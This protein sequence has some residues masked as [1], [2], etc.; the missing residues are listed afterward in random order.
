MKGKVA[1]VT[2]GGQGIGK[3]IAKA[4]VEAGAKVAIAEIDEDAGR[5]TERQLARS[6]TVR[7]VPCDVA[8]EESVQDCVVTAVRR[9]GRLDFVINNA[10]IGMWKPVEQ[11]SV[12][13]WRRV[14]DT[15]LT[16]TFLFARHAARY[17]RKTRGAI[18]NIASTRA[19][20]SEPNTEA[21]SASKG[22]VVSLTHSLA[23]SLGPAIRVNCISPGWIDVNG[24]KKSPRK[25]DVR[26]VDRAFHPV[27]RVGEPED[28][29]ATAL[30]LCSPQA[31]FI[32]G[33]NVTI[34]GGVTR[35]MIYPQ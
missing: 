27:G 1:I 8:S 33:I 25:S 7:F 30:F 6:G 28:I 23:I 4:F 14:L 10:G 31:G 18:V 17:L 13:E 9:F 20:M 3:A 15:N 21:Y 12:D 16:G 32:T 19:F 11:L 22:G 5:K 2:G 35:K 34:D 26:P 29:A 24:W